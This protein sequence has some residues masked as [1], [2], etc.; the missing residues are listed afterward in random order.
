MTAIRG[1]SPSPFPQRSLWIEVARL[2]RRYQAESQR[3]RRGNH[4]RKD[5]RTHIQPD[6]LRRSSR[7]RARGQR[8]EP[9]RGPIGDRNP[10]GSG[11]CRQ[12]EAF[13]DH[14][15][16]ETSATGTECRTERQ[17]AATADTS[18]HQQPREI[19]AGDRE[20]QSDNRHQ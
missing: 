12:H 9:L 16:H 18:G 15:A 11:T 1:R 5:Q 19:H 20:H 7:Q 8:R 17:L 2:A 14:L 3:R 6:W 13:D 10:G 4:N